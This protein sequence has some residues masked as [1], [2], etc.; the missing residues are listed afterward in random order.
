MS[1]KSFCA[2]L[3]TLLNPCR[4]AI[5]PLPTLK[6]AP[7][8]K[9][10]TEMQIELTLTEPAPFFPLLQQGF[11][12]Q[13]RMGNSVRTFLTEDLGIDPDYLENR[14]QTIFLNGHPVDDLSETVVTD[15]AVIALSAAMPGLVGATMRRSG[16]LASFR[17]GITYRV[18]D[19]RETA[20]EGEVT[21]KLFNLLVREMGPGF[22]ERGIWV[23]PDEVA[24]MIDTH[25]TELD[26]SCQSVKRDGQS[27]PGVADLARAISTKHPDRVKLIV[28]SPDM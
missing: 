28:H 21:V 4:I 10:M 23:N 5:P 24:G 18:P 19:A 1:L 11:Q 2:I 15:G 14:I 16:V 26:R 22:L 6:P 13:A 9:T 3:K 7:L 25:G 8:E 17:N 12:V 27:R 20:S